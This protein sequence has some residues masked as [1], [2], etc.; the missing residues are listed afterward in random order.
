MSTH[1]EPL[2]EYAIAIAHD[3]GMDGAGGFWRG[4]GEKSR[5][6]FVKFDFQ[7]LKDLV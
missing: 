1:L 6:F 2:N 3:C 4:G 7:K 5:R